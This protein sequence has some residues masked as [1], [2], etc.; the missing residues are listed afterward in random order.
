MLRQAGIP[1]IALILLL[2]SAPTA[3]GELRPYKHPAL[4]MQFSAGHG[5]RNQ[6]RPGDEG[7]SELVDPET[8]I[9]VLMWMTTTEQSA[10]G[11]LL[12]MSSMMD[13]IPGE[14]LARTIGGREAWLMRAPGTIE[15]RAVETLLAVIPSGK[16]RR[17]PFENNLYIV[18]IWC[19]AE[20]H[21]RL[22]ARMEELLQ[23]V[24]VTDRVTVQGCGLRLYPETMES[25]PDPPSP[26]E[27]DDGRMYVTVRTRDGRYATAPVTV[28]NGAPNDYANGEWGKGRQLHVDGDDFPTLAG[29]GL[30]A[31]EELERTTSITGRPVTDIN[32]EAKPGNASISGFVAEDEELISVIRGDNELVTR[33]GL[34]HP[35]LA[36]PLFMIFNLVLRDL[37]LARRGVV[38]PYNIAALLYDKRVIHI[39]ASAS[40]G[41]QE[42][43]FSDGVRGYWSITIRRE[44]TFLEKRYLQGRYGHLG[45]DKLKIL[46][47]KLTSIHFS[48]MAPFYIMRYGFYE[49]HTGYRADPMAIALLFRLSSIEEI[50]AAVNGDLYGALTRHYQQQ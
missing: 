23:T 35:Q 22:A 34:T 38:Q 2:L 15:D 47:E 16:S 46:T 49:G 7:T 24:R 50:D 48:E 25:P 19:P 18:R 27:A 43:I 32:A 39:E 14:A 37:E 8:G 10:R 21:P 5:W 13:V 33:L 6:P 1:T 45:P 17:H 31:D 20:D 26:F 9:H 42:S 3:A 11:Y 4:D 44:P 29:T 36:K 30:H 12:K 41:W 40:K 28:E